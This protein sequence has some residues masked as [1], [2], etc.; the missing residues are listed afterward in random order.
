MRRRL[1][2]IAIVLLL[3]W[4]VWTRILSPLTG[5]PEELAN[6]LESADTAEA[7]L[8]AARDTHALNNN[9]MLT[10]GQDLLEMFAGTLPEIAY[11]RDG[12]L[13]RWYERTL[14][15]P[16]ELKAYNPDSSENLDFGEP[17]FWSNNPSCFPDGAGSKINFAACVDQ[18]RSTIVIGRSDV[19]ISLSGWSGDCRA[20]Y[21]WVF[22]RFFASDERERRPLGHHPR[23]WILPGSFEASAADCLTDDQVDLLLR[24]IGTRYESWP[25]PEDD[26]E[27][28]LEAEEPAEPVAG[29]T[30][31][32]TVD[33]SVSFT[34]L[35]RPVV[36]ELCV[37]KLLGHELAPEEPAPTDD[38]G[39]PVCLGQD[40]LERAFDLFADR[41]YELRICLP[42][43]PLATAITNGDA[44]VATIDT[45]N[46]PAATDD[47]PVSLQ[48]CHLGPAPS[49]VDTA[50][51]EKL[52]DETPSDLVPVMI[53][54]PSEA[55]PTRPPPHQ[56][57]YPLGHSHPHDP[58]ERVTQPEIGPENLDPTHLAASDER[59]R[60]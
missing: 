30:E 36:S 13:T 10:A 1:L 28:L 3:C 4:I 26:F 42:R 38:A 60:P 59:C 33:V 32:H 22:S 34:L 45:L 43:I 58:S 35:F 25:V 24:R 53:S 44:V 55:I 14:M 47:W 52:V 9:P 41:R 57:G 49:S 51:D 39:N 19:T 21:G 46:M 29:S 7:A 56:P 16:S 15:S 6:A 48:S 40:R 31:E 11:Q 5:D 18:S 20:A 12:A 23:S 8:Q 2:T 54:C 17:V 27:G 37:V 50:Q